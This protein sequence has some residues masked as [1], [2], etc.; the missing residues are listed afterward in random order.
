MKKRK[1]QKTKKKTCIVLIH[2]NGRKS[3]ALTDRLAALRCWRTR[4]RV[5]QSN[6]MFTKPSVP[7]AVITQSIN[8]GPRS[9][10][11][12]STWGWGGGVV[13]K[14]LQ[15]WYWP[16]GQI[17]FSLFNHAVEIGASEVD[18]VEPIQR[19]C[20]GTRAKSCG[21]EECRGVGGWGCGLHE[22]TCPVTVDT[23]RQQQG[24]KRRSAGATES[25]GSFTFTL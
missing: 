19:A 17:R 1:H 2:S 6:L 20:R 3:T 22:E 21:N 24:L 16:G 13:A 5:A 8:S 9:I 14:H 7:A 12:A 10:W 11:Q 18:G 25:S 15:M 23:W 4:S